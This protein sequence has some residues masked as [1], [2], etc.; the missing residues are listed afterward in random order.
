MGKRKLPDD[1][2]ITDQMR[3]WARGKVP[4]L[5]IDHH[6]EEFV[7]HWRANGKMMADWTATWRVWMR[8]TLE[9]AFRRTPKL[10][11]VQATRSDAAQVHD[12]ANLRAAKA[13]GIDPAG[14]T[15]SQINN[16]IWQAQQNAR[17]K[18]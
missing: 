11:A 10:T 17:A 12:I 2:A 3:E 4:R 18:G 14:M 15:D 13:Y 5:D 1:F 7:D 9:G 8:R 16:A 6:T